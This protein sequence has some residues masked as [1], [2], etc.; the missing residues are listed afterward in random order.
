[1]PSRLLNKPPERWLITL[2]FAIV[3]S[4]SPAALSSRKK[5]YLYYVI[6]VICVFVFGRSPK[7]HQSLQVLISFYFI[8]RKIVNMRERRIPCVKNPDHPRVLGLEHHQQKAKWFSFYLP[9]PSRLLGIFSTILLMHNLHITNLA[10]SRC[11]V[12]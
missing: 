10:A 5:T 1:M 6:C 11:T 8:L 9:T 4:G 12:Q 2:H 3:P 7:R